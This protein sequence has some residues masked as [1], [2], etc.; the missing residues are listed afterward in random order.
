M[1]NL[2]KKLDAMAGHYVDTLDDQLHKPVVHAMSGQVFIHGTSA[3]AN[4]QDCYETPAQPIA[5]AAPQ[6]QDVRPN[7]KTPCPPELR[8]ANALGNR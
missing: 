7:G 6:A 4:A 8:Q 3:A 1:K 5:P 2:L